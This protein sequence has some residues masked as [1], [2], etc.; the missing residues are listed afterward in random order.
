MKSLYKDEYLEVSIP[1]SYEENLENNNWCTKHENNYKFHTEKLGQ[2]LIR[3]IYSDVYILSLGVNKNMEGQWIDNVKDNN[4][5]ST[6][7]YLR[8]LNNIFDTEKMRDISKRH[9]NINLESMSMRV[10]GI[11]QLIREKILIYISE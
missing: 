3:F 6:T 9:N 7:I 8:N 11:S 4:N 1:E 10:E 5:H 2:K